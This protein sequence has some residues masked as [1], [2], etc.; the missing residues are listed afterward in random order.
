MFG[1]GGM[2]SFGALGMV[3]NVGMVGSG[4]RAPG[5]GNDG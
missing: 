1:R 5:L 3:G 4:G 2:L